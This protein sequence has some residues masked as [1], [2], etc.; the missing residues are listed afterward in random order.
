MLLINLTAATFHSIESSFT[1][2]MLFI[3]EKKWLWSFS[4]QCHSRISLKQ[5]WLFLLKP[6]FEIGP[7]TN[8]T[9]K[10]NAKSWFLGGDAKRKSLQTE[11]LPDQKKKGILLQLWKIK[12]TCKLCS[13]SNCY[14][15]ACKFRFRFLKG[16]EQGKLRS[17][18][19]RTFQGVWLTCQTNSIPFAH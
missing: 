13:K 8:P 5:K 18:R 9:E 19:K 4:L 15:A 1:L 17:R 2:F 14:S 12:R 11:I 6:M 7:K 10:K 3:A 16:T